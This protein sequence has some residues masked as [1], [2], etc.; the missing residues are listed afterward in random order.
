MTITTTTTVYDPSPKWQ[1]VATAAAANDEFSAVC[2]GNS[3]A[4]AVHS[5]VPGDAVKGHPREPGRDFTVV[6]SAAGD[7]LYVRCPAPAGYSITLMS[8]TA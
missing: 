1:L 4:Y 5:A 6:A 2:E 8:K 3:A 7:K